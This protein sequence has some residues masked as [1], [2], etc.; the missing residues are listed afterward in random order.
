MWDIDVLSISLMTRANTQHLHIVV[1]GFKNTGGS[2]GYNLYILAIL[3][4][5]SSLCGTQ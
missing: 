4:S 5:L 3:F 1:E 2:L